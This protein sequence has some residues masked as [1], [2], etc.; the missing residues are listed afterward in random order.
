MT[1]VHHP[2]TITLGSIFIDSA[3]VFSS[4]AALCFH[5]LAALCKQASK[6]SATLTVAPPRKT[7]ADEKAFADQKM[8]AEPMCA[9]TIIVRAHLEIRLYIYIYDIYNN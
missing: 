1:S 3:T 2:R 7:V 4:A 5:A 9:S 8:V 6:Q